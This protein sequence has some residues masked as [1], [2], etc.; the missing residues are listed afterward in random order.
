MMFSRLTEISSDVAG[1]DNLAVSVALGAANDRIS[2][3]QTPI[4]SN[5]SNIGVVRSI[6]FIFGGTGRTVS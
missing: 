4:T 6:C 3:A 5:A 1:A 2:S